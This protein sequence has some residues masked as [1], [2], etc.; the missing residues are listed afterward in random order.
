[1]PEGP[2]ILILKEACRPFV[3]KKIPNL[4]YRRNKFWKKSV[5]Q[6]LAVTAPYWRCSAGK[7]LVS[8]VT[9]TTTFTVACVA[10]V[11]CGEFYERFLGTC[12]E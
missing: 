11:K 6:D 2:S 1:M 8:C 4:L 12:E 10:P 3:G 9:G 7:E 5:Y